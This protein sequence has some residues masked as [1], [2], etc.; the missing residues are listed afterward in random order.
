[1]TWGVQNSEQEA[2]EQ[3]EYALSEGINFIDTAEMYPVPV[4][5]DLQGKTETYIGS[6]LEKSG[7]R[8]DIILASKVASKNQALSIGTRDASQGLTRDSIREALEGSLTRLQTD[9]LDLY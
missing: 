4:Q 1:M 6:W 9:Y 2:H 3:I 7:K 5:K 8:N